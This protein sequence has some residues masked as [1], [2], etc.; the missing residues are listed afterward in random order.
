MSDSGFIDPP[1]GTERARRRRRTEPDIERGVSVI[2]EHL[3]TMPSA[4][5]VYRMLDEDGDVLYVGKARSLKKRVINYTHP[6][7][8]PN[9][10]FRM[11]SETARMEVVTT[12][13]EVE[14]LLLESNL[15]K[16]LKPRYNVLLRDDKSFPHILMTGDHTYPQIVKHRGARS[17]KGDYFGPFASAGAVNRTIAALQRAF[18]LRN[19]TDSVFSART[20]PCLQYQIKRCS[21][22]CV[23]F[24]EQAE[25]AELVDEARRF[26][27]GR[28]HDVQQQL[29][30]KM[31]EAAEALEFETAAIYRNRIRALTAIQAH[32]DI[33]VDGIEEA[34]VIA[35]H[36]EGG[37]SCIQVFFFRAGS[38]FGNRA[39]FPS[40]D[41]ETED[42]D[43]LSA[44][45]GQ[46]YDDK[47]PP[48]LILIS[49]PVPEASLMAEALSTRAGRK[50]VLL[51]PQRGSK[52]KLMEHATLNAR[53]ALGRRMAES[54]SQRRLLEGVAQ[55]FGLEA[56]PERVEVYDN[57][58]T[59]GTNS[60]GGMIV[61]GPEGFIKAAYRKFNIRNVDDGAQDDRVDELEAG[62]DYAMMRQVLIR[63][64]ARA[65]KEDPERK[66]G[67]WPDLV[68][69]DGGAAHLAVAHEVFAELGIDDL[70]VASIAKGPDRDAGRERFFMAGREPFMLERRDPVLYFL[71]RLRDEAHRFAIETHRARRTKALGGNPL[72]EISGI[73]ARRKKALLH[74]FG[75]ARGVARAGL[76]DLN[77]VDGISTAVAKRVYDFFHDDG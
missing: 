9:R 34:D 29:A 53:E 42:G 63:R 69:I 36:G 60:V 26:L 13:T 59:G 71:Q 54:A 46:F 23:G 37:H 15:I 25:Y 30:V 57:S 75:S 21:A 8:L 10:I 61:A 76:A 64:F 41:K 72:D 73:G 3:R 7:K 45:L 70:A 31:Q 28:S 4:P 62:D 49:H 20:R 55:V 65:L 16:R 40:H 27:T 33:N 12:H 56:T 1:T 11:I 47:P 14:A 58:H 38:N 17:R 51:A 5:G 35:L 2:R 67:T 24:V 77:A 48:W 22:P 32:Q 68:L 74:H 39:Y 19:C 18:L 66:S 44:F 52:R 6:A 43:V 50:V